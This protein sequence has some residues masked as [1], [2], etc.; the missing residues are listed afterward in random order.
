M[1]N[2]EESALRL[3]LLLQRSGK[4][5]GRISESTLKIISERQRLKIGFLTQLQIYLNDLSIDLIQL[6]RGGFAI[7]YTSIFD[8]I[9]TLTAKKLLP[10]EEREKLSIEDIRLELDINY[11]ENTELDD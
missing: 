7:F 6:D 8:G 3:A 10:R 2:Y 9:P 1:I 5:K 4:N 11:E